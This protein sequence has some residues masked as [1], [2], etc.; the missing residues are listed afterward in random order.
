MAVP[1]AATGAGWYDEEGFLDMLVPW[2]DRN[3]RALELGCGAGRISRHVAPLVREL[4]CTD[5]SP[6][7]IA[8]ARENLRGFANVRP[9]VTDGFALAK[10][11]DASFDVAFGQGVLGYLPPNQALGLLAESRRVLRPGGVSVFNF[12]TL[13]DTQAAARHLAV[14]LEQAGKRRVHGGIDEAYTRAQLETM[15]SVAGLTVLNPD[16]GIHPE[17]GGRRIAIVGRRE[18]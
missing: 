2:L 14:V 11:A 12:F 3:V 13:D 1:D 18:P 17:P 8:E 4:V 5:A 6:A 9:A 10:F 7:M 15:H 16:A